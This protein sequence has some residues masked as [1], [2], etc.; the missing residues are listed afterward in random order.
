M[1]EVLLL[2]KAKLKQRVV[3]ITDLLTREMFVI[4]SFMVENG[5]KVNFFY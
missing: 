5:R 2:Q 1:D 3:K 4:G